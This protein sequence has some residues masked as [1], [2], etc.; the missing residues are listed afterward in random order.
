M[1]AVIAGP[2]AAR[3]IAIMTVVVTLHMKT[4][5]AMNK[6]W[7]RWGVSVAG[8]VGVYALAGGWGL[9]YL[10]KSR[11]PTLVES[12]WERQ[13]SVG[14][15][16]FNPFTL[17]LHVRD[18][19]LAEADGA[20][21]FG[22]GALAVELQWRSLLRQAW[23]L[24]EIRVTAPS[25]QLA[26]AHD[27][28]FNLARLIDT[29]NRNKV[30][31][32]A[33]AMPRVVL[34]HFVLEQGR[35]AL[36]D[37]RAGYD[38]TFA[39]LAFELHNLNTLPDQHGDYTLSADAG[40]GGKL[41]W[42]GKA[43]LNPIAAS[44]ALVL[45]NVALPGL[46]SYLKPYT[47][48][49]VTAGRLSA[50]VPYHLTYADGKLDAH[51]PGAT[52][53]LD[54]LAAKLAAGPQAT[55]DRL[56]LNGNVHLQTA[57][58][59][60]ALTVDGAAL[61]LENLALA[62][63]A[64]TPW[65]LARFAVDGGALDLAARRAS[66]ARVTA[67]GGQLDLSRDQSGQF[68]FLQGWPATGGSDPAPATEARPWV[69]SVNAVELSK[70]GALVDDG[71]TGI[72]INLQDFYL[73]LAD[74]GTDLKHP[75]TFDGGVDVREGGRLTARGSFVPAGGVVDAELALNG[76]A[77]APLQPVLDR[78]VKLRLDGGTVA[79]AGR[80]RTRAAGSDDPA[81]HYQGA[82]EVAD[83]ALNE[84]DGHRFA[85]WK[86][87]RAEQLALTVGPDKLDVAE[88]RV[89]EP[90]AIVLINADRSI[91]A[92]RLLVA[93]PAPAEATAPA[94]A[95]TGEAF[96]V[97]IRRMRFDNAKLDFTDLSLRPQFA[98][99]VV[100][101]NGLIT[102][103]STRPGARAQIELDG[104]VDEYGMAR[105]RG[106]LDPFALT[107]QTD[108]TVA[109]K[110]LDLVS[111]SPYSMKFAGYKIAAGKVS[112][113]LDYRVRHGQLEGSNRMVLD[114]LTLGERSD[115]P[116][117]LQL[118]LQLAL[119][120]LKDADGRIDL[121]VPVTGNLD[122]PQFSYGAVVWKA[123]GNI[124][125]KAV[126][127]P[128][129]ALGRLFGVDG[130]RLQ[131][132]EFD[133][134]SERLLPPER[135]KLQQVA[136]LLAKKPVLALAVPG[137]Y[138]AAVDGPALRM[139]AL[140]RTVLARAGVRLDAGEQPGPLDFG[141][142]T[143]RTAMRELYSEQFGAAALDQ[144]KTAAEL[145]AGKAPLVQRLRHLVQGEP[146]VADTEP[147]YQALQAQ[148][149][150]QQ[151]LPPDALAQLGARRAAAIVARLHQAGVATALAG[152]PQPIHGAAGQPVALTLQLTTN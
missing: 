43:A 74:V 98:A 54:G 86:S 51:L 38:E 80:L 9:P 4:V 52:V 16:S 28:T 35:I 65:T 22:V 70:F 117:A 127:S 89:V 49:V 37:R 85:H 99:R 14:D 32:P 119:A 50:T 60:P 150:Q 138:D 23:S 71:A 83:L 13:A 69:A 40:Q 88:L 129:R 21:L 151:V 77:L 124:M 106:Q 136:Q 3:A 10:I 131:A 17:R 108:V 44:G 144:Q 113:D 59:A 61:V 81:L 39:P 75:L 152:A 76:L 126:T 15:V 112:L 114:Q 19:V 110:N 73:N 109:F 82:F 63:G 47:D 87:V 1:P 130:E 67:Q 132:V 79:A 36:H 91:N 118:P 2:I 58:G 148:L 137:Q 90:S 146:L 97:R 8:V 100:D 34:D 41:Y 20:P 139:Q 30:D 72:K 101:L 25:L 107:E 147:F 123:I 116:E 141:A 29:L 125:G 66:V 18:L 105:I 103:L 64:Q 94:V 135:E 95:A 27:G 7:K 143:L 33:S 133:A 111:A 122:D 24:A 149:V 53:A 145:A 102:G 121:G 120:L 96:P 62:H 45:R 48:V 115:S 56:R 68:L 93:R 31:E 6:V 84:H 55:A 26:I 57:A 46:S 5:R 140:R 134:G 104:R 11:L 128:F 142:R 12:R 78:Y 92:Q 42:Q